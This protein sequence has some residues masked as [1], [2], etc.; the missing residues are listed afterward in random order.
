MHR[1]SIRTLMAVILVSAIGL[2]ALRNANGIWAG[3]MMQF[4]LAA[5][6]VAVIG[7][8]ISR[9]SERYWWTGFWVFAGGYLVLVFAPG[10]STEI[11]PKLLTTQF[12]AYVH[13]QVTVSD[14]DAFRASLITYQRTR[15]QLQNSSQ[16]TKDPNDPALVALRAKLTSEHGD[17]RSTASALKNSALR[18]PPAVFF[19]SILPAPANRWRA[20]LPGA[21]NAEEFSRV[22][23]SL[24]AL[25][26]GLVGGTVALWFYERRKRQEAP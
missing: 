16:Q 25:L 22:G 21:A 17:I 1:Y 23:H 26:A 2:A 19:S 5:V 7:A 8:V 24:F 6:G 11:S 14:R 4:A 12:L 3:L 15:R 20:M 18:S 13:S 10:V 9:G